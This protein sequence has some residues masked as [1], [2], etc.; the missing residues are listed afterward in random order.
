MG[1]KNIIEL[2][3]KQYNAVTGALL[4][5]PKKAKQ[6]LKKSSSTIDGF[7]NKTVNKL[8]ESLQSKAAT[9]AV[10]KIDSLKKLA[11]HHIT[12]ARHAHKP[13]RAKTLMRSAVKRPTSNS[14]TIH[15]VQ[16]PVGS[17]SLR[18]VSGLPVAKAAL[19]ERRMIRSKQISKSRLISR[20]KSQDISPVT[21]QVAPIPVVK[22]LNVTPPVK[23]NFQPTTKPKTT[24]SQSILAAG[25]AKATSHQE[26]FITP[27]QAKRQK[28]KAAKK[29]R[30]LSNAVVIILV[31]AVGLI[32]A[33][34][35]AYKDLP[36][37][38]LHFASIRSGVAAEM[39]GYLPPGFK[40][41]TPVGYTHGSVTVSFRSS[42]NNKFSIVQQASDWDS[43]TLHDSFVTTTGSSYQTLQAE[44][45]TIYIYGQGNATWVNAGIWY[46]ISGNANLSNN[47]LISIAT[48]M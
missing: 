15:N 32:V 26:K 13:E 6:G 18:L 43:Q 24:K 8:S 2:N 1:D 20:F 19:N 35:F 42:G 30:L 34:F 27:T 22:A 39:P 3:G 41:I 16:T 7:A 25:L 10:P 33:G 29:H 31:I 46:Q 11:P 47:Q 21:K 36:S 17:L 38:E 4:Q 48:S 23:A 9:V 40:A 45:R 12:N 44:G 37:I 28:R 5:V 14:K